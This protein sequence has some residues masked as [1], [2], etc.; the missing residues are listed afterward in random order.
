MTDEEFTLAAISWLQGRGYTVTEEAP[1]VPADVAESERLF[2]EFWA[3][4]PSSKGKAAARKAFDRLG[5]WRPSVTQS[6]QKQVVAGYF[7]GDPKYFPH[8]ST[9]LN[10]SRWKDDLAKNDSRAVAGRAIDDWVTNG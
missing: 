9:W 7:N 10:Q 2:N 3:V 8:A 5:P 6:L 4:Y 1:T